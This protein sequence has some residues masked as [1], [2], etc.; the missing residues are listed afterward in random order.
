M[1]DRRPRRKPAGAALQRRRPK[2][3]PGREPHASRT[4]RHAA[5][6]DFKVVGDFP[7]VG[8]PR[9]Q[10]F[11]A[12]SNVEE[13]HWGC[14]VV[15]WKPLARAVVDEQP[16]EEEEEERRFVLRTF[17]VFDADQVEGER[18]ISRCM[19]DGGQPDAQ[20]DFAPA[21]ELIPATKADI[22]YGG[23]RAYY[24][25]PRREGTFPNHREGDFIC[26]RPRR[27][28]IR[29]LVLRNRRA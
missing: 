26:F 25:R 2:G 19:E 24:V 16:G 11:Q 9:V 10:H 27:P 28:L 22:R 15:F 7:N 5:R 18:R 8:E 17:T 12:T 3:V 20:P 29:R 21:E 6:A 1:E 13:G 23:S 4:P 14:R